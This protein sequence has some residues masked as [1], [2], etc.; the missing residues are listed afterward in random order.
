MTASRIVEHASTRYTIAD[1]DRAS[2]DLL[3][4][5]VLRTRVVDE[6][7]LAAPLVPIALSST[8]RGARPRTA[9]GGICGLVGRPR[10]VSPGMV[11]PNGF[12]ARVT[13]PGYLPRDL[14]PAI[15]QAR[16][17]LNT[18]AGAGAPTLDVL[19]ADPAPRTQ[20]KPGRGVLLARP[21]P[22]APEQFTTVAPT[23]APPAATDVPLDDAVGTLRPAGTR[24]AGVPL[25]LPDQPLHRDASLPIRGRVRLRTLP[26]VVVPAVGADVGILGIW[27]DYPSSITG[28][29]L[30]P[31]VCAVRPTLRLAH[32]VGVTVHTCT[33]NPVGP[34]RNLRDFAPLDA[35]ELVLAPN[36][37][38]NAL[39]GDL[40]RVGDPLTADD[41]VVVTAGFDATADPDAP[42][43]VR[44][45]TPLGLIHRGGDPVHAVQ[46]AGVA[47]VGNVAREALAGDP[48]L[49]APGLPA[50]PT[51]S[52]VIVEN[53]TPRAAYYRATQLPSTPD[54]I[55]FNHQV[56]LD[57]TG[58]FVW[59]SLARVAQVRVVASLPPN[60]PAQLDVALDYGGDATLAIVL[61]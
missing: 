44:L 37:L 26:N 49:F 1:D 14:T 30:A 2:D 39:G 11:T 48:V 21:T 20:F 16:R 18:A 33:L 60:V 8:L 42:V 13:A 34:A 3:P 56:P 23:A 54:G 36:N 55:V 29:P 15:E 17:T 45:R 5:A 50:L 24:V 9:D 28:A 19:P 58:R 31:D 4:W 57:F 10:D 52:T 27:W 7:T 25:A 51:V 38:L 35:R 41:E 43:R 22:T 59:P 46:A 47:P 6:L 32:P 53:G 61:T 40:L 12:T